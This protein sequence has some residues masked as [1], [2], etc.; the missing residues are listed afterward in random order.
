MHGAV[1]GY[2]R[3]QKQ[4]RSAVHTFHDVL[5]D[6]VKPS[7]KLNGYHLAYYLMPK[8]VTETS[9]PVPKLVLKYSL[10]KSNGKIKQFRNFFRLP[11]K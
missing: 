3:P 4:Y 6:E 11:S 2:V 8:G 1:R 10:L 7:L 9:F 5:P